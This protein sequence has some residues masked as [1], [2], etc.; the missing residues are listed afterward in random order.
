MVNS[1]PAMP[2]ADRAQ[3]PRLVL[4]RGWKVAGAGLSIM[5]LAGALAD[6]V[7]SWGETTAFAIVLL[8]GTGVIFVGLTR[9]LMTRLSRPRAAA[10]QRNGSRTLRVMTGVLILGYVALVAALAMYGGELPWFLWIALVAWVV[11]MLGLTILLSRAENARSERARPRAELGFYTSMFVLG[12]GILGLGAATIGLA[13]NALRRGDVFVFATVGVEAVAIAILGALLLVARHAVVALGLLGVGIMAIGFGAGSIFG[14]DVLFGWSVVAVGVATLLSS[15]ATLR[16]ADPWTALAYFT[17]GAAAL[18]A[19]FTSWA[20]REW[21]LAFAFF[22]VGV[23]LCGA[24]AFALSI[25]D[26][27]M[28]QLFRHPNNLKVWSRNRYTVLAVVASVAVAV[29]SAWLAST[30]RD[31]RGPGLFAVGGITLGLLAVQIALVVALARREPPT[32]PAKPPAKA[33]ARTRRAAPVGAA[34]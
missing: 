34:K 22:L 8:M 33:R 23:V 15:A 20:Q 18:F 27:D 30:W 3:T 21:V 13:V 28:A 9:I 7:L 26:K 16:L 2:R 14:G 11:G 12:I 5:P 17:T 6:G 4:S 25:T 10:A 32:A 31:G 19:T 24:T 1:T 29:S